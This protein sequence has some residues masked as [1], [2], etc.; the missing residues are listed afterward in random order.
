MVVVP[1]LYDHQ[2]LADDEL[3]WRRAEL[4]GASMI[5]SD[6]VGLEG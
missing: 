1:L 6:R 4:I 3:S 5:Q 2:S